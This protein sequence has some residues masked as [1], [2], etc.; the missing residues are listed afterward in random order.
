MMTMMMMMCCSDDDY[1]DCEQAR[2]IEAVSQYFEKK[3]E[4]YIRQDKKAKR[5]IEN[6]YV[7]VDWL[8]QCMGKRCGRCQCQLFCEVDKGNIDCNITAQRVENSIG[9]E[10]SNVIPYCVYCNIGQ[11]NR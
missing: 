8:F 10:I 4:G 5:A 9:H 11:S 6:N 1:D 3:V 2:N 7:S